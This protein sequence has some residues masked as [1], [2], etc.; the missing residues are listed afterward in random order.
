MVDGK[1]DMTLG[2]DHKVP[3]N[4]ILRHKLPCG[5][6]LMSRTVIATVFS[7]YARGPITMRMLQVLSK[8]GRSF[9]VS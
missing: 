1:D 7:F 2:F 4:E 9:A 6:V 5:K 3:R 8:R